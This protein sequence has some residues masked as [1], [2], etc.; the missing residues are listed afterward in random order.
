MGADGEGWFF[1][2]QG[3]GPAFGGDAAAVIYSG[4]SAAVASCARIDST[5][6]A[7]AL[8]IPASGPWHPPKTKAEMEAT[9]P[10]KI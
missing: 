2:S 5:V 9:R 1:L 10:D 4:P 6:T 3:N 7:T 8:K